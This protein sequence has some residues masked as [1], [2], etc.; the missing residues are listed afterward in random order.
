MTTGT[1]YPVASAD[2]GYGGAWDNSSDY[3]QIGYSG[4]DFTAAIRFSADI[5]G[6]LPAAGSTITAAFMRLYA[7]SYQANTGAGNPANLRLFMEA[8]DTPAQ[9]TDKTDAD[10]RD[11]T[12]AYSDWD[13]GDDGWGVDW[14]AHDT[15]SIVT[16]VQEVVSRVGFSGDFLQVFI[17]NRGGTKNRF[18]TSLDYSG[19][20]YKPELH[21]E[22]TEPEPAAPSGWTKTVNGVLTPASVNGVLAAN[23]ASING[24]AA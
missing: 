22:W 7:Y 14:S 1:F 12:T 15:P 21:L 10:G 19:G 8:A 16:A 18:V 5:N 3:F 6:E 4:N 17:Q 13:I 9:I 11:R 24:V 20:L 23:I 2:D